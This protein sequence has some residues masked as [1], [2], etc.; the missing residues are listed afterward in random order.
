MDDE[1][2]PK[3]ID[4]VDKLL[5]VAKYCVDNPIILLGISLSGT[6]MAI[7]IMLNNKGGK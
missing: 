4:N 7:C 3:E 2:L 1:A 6:I 5:D